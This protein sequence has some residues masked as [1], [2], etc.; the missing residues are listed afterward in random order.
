MREILF[1]GKW[2]GTSAWAIGDLRVYSQ[3]NGGRVRIFDKATGASLE[4]DPDTV[5]QYTGL[6]DRNGE[7]IFEGDIVAHF[8]RRWDMTYKEVEAIKWDDVQF[9][10]VHHNLKGREIYYTCC[11]NVFEV[12]GNI[13]DNP[14][15][16]ENK[17]G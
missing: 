4:V 12:I 14:E 9:R 1:R 13:Y 2:K 5:G 16:L 15:L 17:N 10:W 3:K 6:K 8:P 11:D 7:K